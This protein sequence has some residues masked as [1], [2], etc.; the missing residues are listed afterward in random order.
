MIST[1][2]RQHQFNPLW[3][4]SPRSCPRV[5]VHQQEAISLSWLR[6][7]RTWAPSSH[8]DS[9][10]IDCHCFS[11][12][13]LRLAPA[14]MFK[15]AKAHKSFANPWPHDIFFGNERLQELQGQEVSMLPNP[16]TAVA[17]GEEKSE[18]MMGWI[19]VTEQSAGFSLTW[20]APSGSVSTVWFLCLLDY[21]AMR[22][23]IAQP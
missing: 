21:V 22:K 3:W 17:C 2:D 12:F 11:A 14:Y 20:E 6:I 16:E 23:R 13:A 7:S 8:T 1:H 5:E 9:Y 18:E 19:L 4:L 10:C 15:L